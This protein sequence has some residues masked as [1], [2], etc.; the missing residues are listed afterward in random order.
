VEDRWHEAD[1]TVMVKDIYPGGSSSS[2]TIMTDV[3]GT[4]FF[5]ADDGVHGFELWKTDGT[6]AG[7]VMVKDINLNGS[8][9]PRRLTKLGAQLFF[10]AD[11]GVQGEIL[12]K[13]DGTEAGTA[14]VLDLNSNPV[15]APDNLTEMNGVLFFSATDADLGNELWRSDGLPA[16]TRI[17]KDIIPG[18]SSSIPAAFLVVGDQLYFQRY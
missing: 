7:T 12:W 2:P 13:S 5:V 11:D 8:S 4:L 1:G 14:P 10:R 18:A 15:S 9:D 17:V 16:G 6:E 3:N